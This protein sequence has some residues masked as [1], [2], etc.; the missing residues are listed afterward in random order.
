[1]RR[2][3][4]V[5]H[6]PLE[7]GGGGATRWRFLSQELPRHGWEVRVVS[8]RANP[9]ANEFATDPAAARLAAGR[10]AV[11]NRVGALTRPLARRA[12]LQPE[13]LAPSAA[14]ALTG[15]RAVRRALAGHRPDVVVATGPP[16]AAYWVVA[17]L[18]P[19]VP[20]V[21]ELRDLWAGNP[22]YDAG[23][24]VLTAVE[25]RALHRAAAVVCMTPQARDRLAA[26]HPELAGRLQVLP[27]GFDPGLLD[28]RATPVEPGTL[29]HA[30]ALYGGRTLDALEAALR[31]EPRVRLEL[32]GPGTPAGTLPWEAAVR[33]VA[34]AQV[35]LVVFTPGDDTAVPGK[36]YEA[37][38]LGRPVL[39]LAG[40][41][42]AMR[43]VLRE[44]GQDAGLAAADD[45]VA[46]A[47][48]LGRLLDDPPPPVAPAAL[49]P[50]DRARVAA[51][52]AELLD[53]LA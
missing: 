18:A 3:L 30:G 46:I 12:G 6:R 53:G 50:Y 43:P 37:L 22:Y 17:A 21:A 25:G 28:L 52:Y 11:M 44:L 9:T 48:S 33:R 45:P 2:L 32:I 29:L 8:A 14:W 7:Y 13:A 49:A 36:L 26:L 47:A 20:V 5:T 39:A 23:G 1:V 35:A 40:P 15:R 42:S 4:L 38:A 51:R 27:N 16:P 41:D 31:L 34:A 19:A 24:R 10:A